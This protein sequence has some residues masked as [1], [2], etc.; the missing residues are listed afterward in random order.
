MHTTIWIERLHRVLSSFQ[1]LGLTQTGL[2][3][4]EKFEQKAHVRFSKATQPYKLSPKHA[5]F[6]LL[7]RPST[8]DIHVFGQIFVEREYACLDNL[9]SDIEL[10][11]DCG[12]NVGYSSAYFLSRFPN[13]R[14]IAI[15]PDPSNFDVLKTNLAPY[16]ERV[17]L[18][19][20]GVW[21]RSV[22]LKI[23]YRD[24]AWTTE[25]RECKPHELP[26]IQATDIGT[27]L[28]SSD[29]ERI[30]I[31]KVDI[32]G[33]EATLFSENFESW[34]PLVDNIVIEIHN[35]Y[36]SEIFKRAISDRPFEIS[37]AGELTVCKPQVGIS[38]PNRKGMSRGKGDA[39]V[40]ELE[41]TV[42]EVN[43]QSLPVG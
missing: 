21:S 8:S 18:V 43:T 22:G 41:L 37:E 29:A 10:V 28:K 23:E 25:V 35:D 4:K 16:K 9:P 5:N 19:H 30:S 17:K 33:A 15:E 39:E 32:E 27:L 42:P 12:A 36:A 6:P 38:I 34:L 1:N 24:D 3:I 31:L 20:S 26:D 13:C 11:I 7:C 2:F 14:V 40:S